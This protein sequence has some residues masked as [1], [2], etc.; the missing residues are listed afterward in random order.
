[1]IQEWPYDDKDTT[2][3]V[4][5]PRCI[6]LLLK[7]RKKFVSELRSFG[8][9]PIKRTVEFVEDDALTDEFVYVV[10]DEGIQLV[11]DMQWPEEKKKKKK[12]ISA[13]SKKD[14]DFTK[15]DA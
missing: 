6:K 2:Y 9:I 15:Y 12:K 7:S 8:D 14:F 3:I 5:S 10:D 4:S 1:M 13:E 11:V